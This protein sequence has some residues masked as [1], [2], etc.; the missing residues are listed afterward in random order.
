MPVTKYFATMELATSEWNR[1]NETPKV[2]RVGA[3]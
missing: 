3:D 2:I 1:R